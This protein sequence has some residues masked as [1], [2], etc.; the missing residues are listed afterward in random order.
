MPVPKPDKPDKLPGK[1]SWGQS[2]KGE[3]KGTKGKGKGKFMSQAWQ[4]GKS[5]KGK[6]GKG[7]DKTQT[8]VPAALKGLDPNYKG[9]PVCFNHSLPHGC[10]EETWQASVVAEGCT[11]A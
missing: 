4:S 6:S 5:G 7:K 8:S 9:Q 1:R 11:F 2:F 3:D 10:Q